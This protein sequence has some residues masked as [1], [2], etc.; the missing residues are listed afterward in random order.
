MLMMVMK[1]LVP[2]SLEENTLYSLLDVKFR[3][4]ADISFGLHEALIT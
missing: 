4:C 1:S 2:D 3:V